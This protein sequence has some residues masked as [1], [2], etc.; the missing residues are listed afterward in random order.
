MKPFAL[1]LAFGLTGCMSSY[2]HLFRHRT[3]KVG[4]TE[5]IVVRETLLESSPLLGT[6]VLELGLPQDELLVLAARQED[7]RWL[8]RTARETH[9]EEVCEGKESYACLIV[10][11]SPW[12]LLLYFGIIPAVIDITAMEK[13]KEPRRE[14][15]VE[16]ETLPGPPVPFD[17]RVQVPAADAEIEL[18]VVQAGRSTPLGS[19]RSDA[20]GVAAFPL[21]GAVAMP[22]R[23]DPPLFVASSDFAGERLVAEFSPEDPEAV[24][25][26][27]QG[28]DMS[29]APPDD[30]ALPVADVRWTHDGAEVRVEVDLVNEG[31]GPMSGAAVRLGSGEP[32]LD[33]WVWRWGRVEPGER[34][35]RE[36]KLPLPA[37][38]ARAGVP[39]RVAFR[40]SNGFVPEPRATVVKIE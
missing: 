14:R 3:E 27:L 19:R 16:R 8:T 25:A 18:A 36:F 17:E 4:A 7:R 40:E 22:L 10:T 34:A 32:E 15:R 31:A 23:E 28:A 37:A 26:L 1:L 6:E 12:V 35:S 11:Q 38:R 13:H 24:F 39:V 9:Y 30:V 29:A 5:G 20:F 33:G 2:H 21:R